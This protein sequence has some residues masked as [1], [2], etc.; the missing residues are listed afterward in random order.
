[1]TAGRAK[2]RE[3]ESF[4]SKLHGPVQRVPQHPQ[5]ADFLFDLK[6]LKKKASDGLYIP[7]DI[8]PPDFLF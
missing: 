7:P 4:P 2:E 6:S 5:D 3:E 8:K 1:M